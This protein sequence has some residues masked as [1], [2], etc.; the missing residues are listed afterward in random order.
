MLTDT[1]KK[2]CFVQLCSLIYSQPFLQTSYFSV[3]I[4]PLK[5]ASIIPHVIIYIDMLSLIIFSLQKHWLP[6]QVHPHRPVSLEVSQAHNRN[7]PLANPKNLTGDQVILR[8]TDG[9]HQTGMRT[10]GW[11]TLRVS[12]STSWILLN[13]PWFPALFSISFQKPFSAKKRKWRGKES[14]AELR[15]RRREQH[16]RQLGGWVLW[17][18]GKSYEDA[19]LQSCHFLCSVFES[20]SSIYIVI[21]S[22]ITIVIICFSCI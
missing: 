15:W 18:W 16:D 21:F 9:E 10:N 14:N 4:I 19:L 1:K 8:V 2:V 7:L 3:V 17:S 5:K 6:I 13:F 11:I 12:S 22:V 20:S